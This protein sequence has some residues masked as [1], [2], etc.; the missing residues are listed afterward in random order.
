MYVALLVHVA[1]KTEQGGT[2]ASRLASD[3]DCEEKMT[4][5]NSGGIIREWQ[6]R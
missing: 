5:G 3:V 6:K 2:A 4:T 1:R